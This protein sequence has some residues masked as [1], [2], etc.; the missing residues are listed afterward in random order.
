M[1]PTKNR[2]G[3]RSSGIVCNFY[4]TSGTSRDTLVRNP[5]ISIEIFVNGRQ[6]F[7]EYVVFKRKRTPQRQSRI[8]KPETQT[9]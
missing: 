1:T 5:A 2:R 3:I 6:S 4:S 7:R 8:D 9:T